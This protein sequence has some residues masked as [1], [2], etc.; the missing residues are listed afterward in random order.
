[1]IL[2]HDE[3]SVY[4]TYEDITNF[5]EDLIEN[6]I[7]DDLDIYEKCRENFGNYFNIDWIVK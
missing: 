1:M 4:T 3:F 7:I 5:V 6:G 2:H